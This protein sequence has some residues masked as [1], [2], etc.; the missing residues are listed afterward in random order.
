MCPNIGSF[1]FLLRTGIQ[2]QNSLISSF[3]PFVPWYT[4]PLGRVV[5]GNFFDLCLNGKTHL[6]GFIFGS[7]FLI[8]FPN[9]SIASAYTSGTGF[10]SSS[11]NTFFP[12]VELEVTVTLVALFVLGSFFDTLFVTSSGCWQNPYVSIVPLCVAASV[13]SF[14]AHTFP[15]DFR[16][17]FGIKLHPVY[18]LFG[19]PLTLNLST[20]LPP[21][22][23]AS[24]L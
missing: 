19:S 21:F 2:S 22:T 20:H 13:L 1:L 4:R 12:G 14:V 24:L 11:I 16:D 7:G 23:L 15:L 5:N 6:P 9:K 3:L 10:P 8:G 17:I 18:G